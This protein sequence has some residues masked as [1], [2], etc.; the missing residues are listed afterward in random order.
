MIVDDKDP[1]H[2]TPPA[3]SSFFF[4]FFFG[5]SAFSRCT[6]ISMRMVGARLQLAVDDA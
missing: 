2:D 1:G 5:R 4:F 3:S 6:G